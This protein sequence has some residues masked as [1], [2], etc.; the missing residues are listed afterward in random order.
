MPAEGDIDDPEFSFRKGLDL[1][2]KAAAGEKQ[3]FDWKTIKSNGDIFWVE[4]T[5]TPMSEKS[6]NRPSV[7]AI[8][9]DITQRRIN[10]KQLEIKERYQKTINTIIKGIFPLKLESDILWNL[11]ESCGR[12]LGF[13]CS[14]LTSWQAWR[15]RRRK[16]SELAPGDRQR[17]RRTPP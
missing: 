16:R 2:H 6:G 1:V 7:I 8:V 9:R 4:V 10:R 17:V 11:A 14:T 5:L 15:N 13:C 3:V 12:E